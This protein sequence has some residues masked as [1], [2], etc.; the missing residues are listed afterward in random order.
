MPVRIFLYLHFTY[1]F[2]HR[3]ITTIPDTIDDP[4]SYPSFNLAE[5]PQSAIVIGI[6]IAIVICID[7]LV[8]CF[9]WHNAAIGE[10]QLWDK[11]RVLSR[12]FF[13]GFHVTTIP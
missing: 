4:D 7:K 6:T 3:L 2:V 5:V 8:G 12:G 13:K 10:V 11:R 1:F 9:W